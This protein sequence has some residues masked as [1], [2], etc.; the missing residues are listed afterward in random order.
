M[1]ID[2]FTVIPLVCQLDFMHVILKRFM[3]LIFGLEKKID[4]MQKYA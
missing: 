1:K 4:K 3:P 2:I